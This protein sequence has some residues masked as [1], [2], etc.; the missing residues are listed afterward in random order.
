MPNLTCSIITPS[1]NQAAFLE[2][3]ILSVLAQDVSNLEYQ[4]IDGGSTDDSLSILKAYD[5]RLRWI[6]EPDR[7]HSHALNKG[8]ARTSGEIIGWL[9]SDD[10]YYPDAVRCALA[11]FE[12]HPHV[13]VVYGEANWI[14]A[15]DRIIDRYPTEAWNPTR[16]LETC[17]LCQ[18][19]VFFRR[20]VVERWGGLDESL[21]LSIDYEFWVRL[22]RRGAAF[23]Y[24]PQILAGSRLHPHTKTALEQP[25]IQEAIAEFMQKH[26]GYVPDVWVINAAAAHLESKGFQPSQQV[27]FAL[28]LSL[29]SYQNSLRYNHR[30]SPA[31]MKTSMRWVGGNVRRVL[32]GKQFMSDQ[33]S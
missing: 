30:I 8:F 13:D 7:G 26:L 6:S 9:N 22:A 15:D 31:L 11:V 17:Y 21:D 5:G 16:L 24:V 25:K 3:T 1:F 29:R 10:V 19:A 23:H 27:R 4:I 14:D 2:R 32:L 28:R 12:V 18:P 33:R 20:R